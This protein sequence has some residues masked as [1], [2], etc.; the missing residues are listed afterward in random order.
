MQIRW[1][2]CQR[3]LSPNPQCWDR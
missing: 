1:I 2:S 3:V